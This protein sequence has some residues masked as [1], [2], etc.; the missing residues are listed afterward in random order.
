M[1]STPVVWEEW[2]AFSILKNEV[3]LCSEVEDKFEIDF[4]AIS[5]LYCIND[6]F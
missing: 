2:A 4:Q 3:A 6:S 1:N 5:P